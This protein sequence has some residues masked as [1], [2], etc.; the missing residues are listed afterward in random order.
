MKF[1]EAK[2]TDT[3]PNLIWN[4]SAVQMKKIAE[5]K[6]YQ[7]INHFPGMN[8][9][10][11]KDSLSENMAKMIQSQPEEF[12][13]IPQTWKLPEECEQ[14]QSYVKKLEKKNIQKTFI[15]KP[16]NGAMGRGIFLI[17]DPKKITVRGN[18]VVQEYLDNPFLMEGYKFDLRIYALVISCDPPRFFL[19]NDGLVRMS[20]EKYQPPNNSNLDQQYMHLTNYS[21]NKHSENFDRDETEDKGSKRSIDWFREYLRT[22]GYD[23]DKFWDDVSELVAKTLIVAQPHV[24]KAYREHRPRDPPG[25]TSV[26]FELLGF[27]VILDRDLKPWLLEI[28]RAPSFGTDDKIDVD[29]KKGALLDALKLLNIRASDEQQN[30]AEQRAETQRRLN[31]PGNIRKRVART[32]DWQRKIQLLERR[33]EELRKNQVQSHKLESRD[34]YA[35]SHLGNYSCIYPPD[36]KLL[37][38]KYDSLLSAAFKTFKVHNNPQKLMKEAEIREQLKQS[39]LKMKK[40]LGKNR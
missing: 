21:V 10:C 36:D 12:S 15:V 13:F 33:I 16:A 23:V 1:R 6:N 4:D 38:E 14:F 29:V 11:R 2:T 40:L 8:E 28:N 24:L 19:Y 3:M 17:Q 20:T 31:E 9:I 27:D 32:V 39:E 18:F 22:S 37:L 35:K 7:W 5:L 26:C 34:E 25:S 30:L